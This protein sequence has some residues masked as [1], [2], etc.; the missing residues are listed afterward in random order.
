M[1]KTL[2]L[3]IVFIFT[4]NSHLM[5]D[6]VVSQP[7]SWAEAEVNAARAKNLVVPEADGN[8]QEYISRELFC[9]L[10]VNMVE[11]ATGNPIVVSIPNPFVDT[12]SE[13]IVKAYQFGIVNGISA[14]QFAP[15]NKIT[16]QEITAMMMRAFRKLD[17]LMGTTFTQNVD[18]SGI[19]FADET[20]ISNWALQDIKEA[21]K[22]GII[23]G[24][25]NNQINPLGNATVEQSILLTLRLYNKVTSG[26]GGS[27]G[28]GGGSSENTAPVPKNSEFGF[29]T[30]DDSSLII[31]ATELAT[32]ADGDALVVSAQQR[33]PSPTMPQG[34]MK[35]TSDGKLEFIVPAITGHNNYT[36]KFQVKVSDGSAESEPF[37]IVITINNPNHAPEAKDT[38]LGF[39]VK[40][41]T[42]K[43]LSVTTI[44]KD[45]DDDSLRITGASIEQPD[46]GQ[47]VITNSK[48]SIT[49]TSDDIPD[50][51]HVTE[52]ILVKVSDGYASTDIPITITVY[53]SANKPPVIITTPAVIQV[54]NGQT[55]TIKITDYVSDDGLLKVKEINSPP[56]IIANFGELSV[57]PVLFQ[58]DRLKFVAGKPIKKTTVTYQV[59]ITDGVWEVELPVKVTVS[60][61]VFIPPG[62]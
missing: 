44:A 15:S 18:I 31:T 7:S 48:T 33:Y 17:P 55:E 11:T 13:P 3:F 54:D 34:N 61:L 32:D 30:T 6:S 14:T 39:I 19:S 38:S 21:K 22:L 52:R 5:V 29:S 25:G 35:I 23:N 20:S 59:T 27:G 16:R 58:S 8:F 26:S 42:P 60:G 36:E 4:L 53:G 40:E 62:P 12:T 28:S 43:T 10:I 50:N 46:H 56:I 41:Q 1:K 37:D 24:V 57:S 45:L 49:Y 47:L 2:A 51:G 9:K